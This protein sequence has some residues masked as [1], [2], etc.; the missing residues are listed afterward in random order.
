MANF[1]SSKRPY[2]S[3]IT[4]KKG[5]LPPRGIPPASTRSP[6]RLEWL[7]SGNTL[8][9]SLWEKYLAK[10]WPSDWRLA[11]LTRTSAFFWVVP[12]GGLRVEGEI[13]WKWDVKK[14]ARFEVPKQLIIQFWGHRFL[15]KS[16]APRA[17]RQ[18]S[19]QILSGSGIEAAKTKR[20][21]SNLENIFRFSRL[22]C[23]PGCRSNFRGLKQCQAATIPSP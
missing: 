6:K 23:S 10:A 9:P 1:R 20:P 18:F 21:T 13:S 2:S 15:R 4:N 3:P 19:D 17:P 8:N 14:G 11:A 5:H 7:N 22:L 12:Y 16:H